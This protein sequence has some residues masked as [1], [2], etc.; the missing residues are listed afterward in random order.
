MARG[1]GTEVQHG[2]GQRIGLLP[3]RAAGRPDPHPLPGTGSGDQGWQ[4]L[5]AQSPEMVCLAEEMGDVDQHLAEQGLQLG[6]VFFQVAGIDIGVFDAE[7]GSAG[8]KAASVLAFE[9]RELKT[10]RQTV[11]V[12]VDR[13]PAWVGVDPYNK[14]IDRNSDDNL[15]QV[16][17][18]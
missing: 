12:V 6:R 14:R 17:R 4:D 5:V 16:V 2:K 3:G 15:R 1:L 8:F 7:P 10:G 11:T 18:P 9:R 13:E